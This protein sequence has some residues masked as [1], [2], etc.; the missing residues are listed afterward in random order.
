[1]SRFLFSRRLSLLSHVYLDGFSY[2]FLPVLLS[3]SSHGFKR[4]KRRR[5]GGD[6]LENYE[7][8]DLASSFSPSHS[9]RWIQLVSLCLVSICPCVLFKQVVIKA[10]TVI[11]GETS[12]INTPQSHLDVGLMELLKLR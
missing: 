12:S 7:L 9:A 10:I 5:G 4:K 1:M 2:I 8:S 3:P 6:K 11:R